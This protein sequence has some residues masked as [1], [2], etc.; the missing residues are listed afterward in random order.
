M[1]DPH[2]FLGGMIFSMFCGAIIAI[3]LG[4]G[5]AHREVVFRC[6]AAESP[7]TVLSDMRNDGM[8]IQCPVHSHITGSEINPEDKT[9]MTRVVCECDK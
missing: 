1:S 6:G 8:L 7:I 5:P 3:L 9:S 4:S 2:E